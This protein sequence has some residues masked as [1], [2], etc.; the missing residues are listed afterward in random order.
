MDSRLVRAIELLAM[1][2]A[3]RIRL[4]QLARQ[5]GLSGRMLELL[6][7]TQKGTGFA[8]YY[9]AMRMALACDQLKKTDQPV[10]VIASRLGYRAVEVLCRD[11]KRTYRCTPH[12][13]RSRSRKE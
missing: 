1:N 10:K 2:P 3:K 5:V 8:R 7:K 13:Y 9:R 6:F 12:E 11:F 4:P